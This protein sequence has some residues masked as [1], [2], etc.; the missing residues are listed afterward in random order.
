MLDSCAL[1]LSALQREG[2]FRISGERDYIT[3]LKCN[4]NGSPGSSRL[5]I[6]KRPQKTNFIELGASG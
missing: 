6:S 2:I 4:V 5:V 1:P 3:K